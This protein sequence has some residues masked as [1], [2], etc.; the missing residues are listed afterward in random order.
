[1]RS[2]LATFVAICALCLCAAPTRS[3]VAG[4]RISA[5]ALP[6]P[7]DA[8]VE[9]IEGTGTQ[10]IDT[11]IDST[12]TMSCIARVGVVDGYPDV[13]IGQCYDDSQDWRLFYPAGTCL[14]I[15]SARLFQN[16]KLT[17]GELYDVSFGNLTMTVDGTTSTG[18]AAGAVTARHILA[19]AK[20]NPYGTYCYKVRIGSILLVDGGVTVR[21]MIAVRQNGVGYMFDRISGELFGNSGTGSFIIGPDK[22]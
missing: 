16:K 11:L 19:M 10:Y 7:Y 3:M 9:Y 17:A 20:I 21:D 13:I 22:N 8:E 12:S 14:D 15:G 2:I 18:V 4:R 6:L 5:T 1:M